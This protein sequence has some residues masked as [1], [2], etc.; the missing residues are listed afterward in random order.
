MNSSLFIDN[1]CFS[2]CFAQDPLLQA[3]DE[4]SPVIEFKT[5]LKKKF[6]YN[7]CEWEPANEFYPKDMLLGGDRGILAYIVV[8]YHQGDI[9]DNRELR[10]SLSK[11]IRMVSYAES[12]LDRPIF[13]IYLLNYNNL[14]GL[15]FETDE[16]IK[17]R[18]YHCGDCTEPEKDI[19]IPNIDTMGD[20]INLRSIFDDLK[21]NNV[22]RS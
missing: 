6:K 10:M 9:F 14:K 19:Y 4:K 8:Q 12:R 13:Y 2:D 1:C 20:F 22:R 21:K 3:N 18:L 17:E 16:Q 5:A 7:I 15:Y 11:T